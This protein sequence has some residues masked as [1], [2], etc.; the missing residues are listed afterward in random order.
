V[1]AL[2]SALENGNEVVA[3]PLGFNYAASVGIPG[4]L[5]S[6]PRTLTEDHKEHEGDL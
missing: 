3:R 2:E 6:L 1:E 4:P 5:E